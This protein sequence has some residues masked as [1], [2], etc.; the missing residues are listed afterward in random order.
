MTKVAVAA[1]NS[2]ALEAGLEIAAE[3]GN[4]VDAAVAASIA[5]MCTDPGMVSIMSGAYVNVWPVDGDPVVI[6]GN[7]EMPGRGLDPDRF[8]QGLRWVTTQYGGGITLGVGAGS[9]A[10]SG[11]VHALSRASELFGRVPWSRVVEPSERSCRDGYAVGAAAAL[12][13]GIVRESLFG[14]DPEAHAIVTGPEGHALRNGEVVTNSDLADIL[15]LLGAQGPS[16][17]TSGAVGRVLVEQME[18]HGGLITREDLLAYEPLERRPTM[19]RL[20][21]WTVALNPPP[22]VGGPKLA[23]MLGE[24]AAPSRGWSWADVIEI[25]QR[26]LAYRLSVHDRSPDLLA[27]GHALLESVDRHGLAGLPT[28]ASTSHVSAV[29]SAGGACSITMSAG[30]GAGIVIPGTGILLNNALGEPELNRLG[31]HALA[32]G[33]RLASNMAPTTARNDAGGCIAV[34]SPGADRITTALMHVLGQALLRGVDLAE[35]IEAPRLHVRFGEDGAPLVE[36]EPDP[37]IAAAIASS[38]LPGSEYPS[39]HMYFGGVGAAQFDG[40]RV[41][42]AADSRREAA[43]GTAS[44]S[45]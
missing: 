11:A 37:A 20:G 35:A 7:V 26:V 10:N 27:D 33:T 19:R 8:G 23:V 34:G 28:S 5:A 41:Q 4:A 2:A 21:D 12:Y 31:L 32:P 18:E 38:G 17:F 30:Y 6:D 22:S 14:D 39:K 3:G 42:A 1:A 40:G 9:V 16:L 36:H 13:L 45:P 24:L 29:D 15:E 44:S 25:Q 43:V